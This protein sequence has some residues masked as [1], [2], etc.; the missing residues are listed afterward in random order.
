MEFPSYKV[1]TLGSYGVGKTCLLIRATEENCVFSSNYMT[2]IGVDFKTKLHNYNGQFFK[3]MIWDTAGQERFHHINRLYYNGCNAAIL[4]YDIT[5]L[6][7]FEKIQTFLDDYNKN[8]DG[9]S[10][11]VLCGN[12]SDSL[13]RQVS[14]D[15]GKKLAS[16]LGIPFIECSAYTGENVNQLFDI[17]IQQLT[18]D[19]KLPTPAAKQTFVISKT[20]KKK[21]CC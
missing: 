2:T 4:V 17:L 10:A 18:R 15:Q 9:T 16:Q 11:I 14:Y 20:K 7:S 12:K 13:N 3:L 8:T 6:F 1:I 5:S 19:N 21:S